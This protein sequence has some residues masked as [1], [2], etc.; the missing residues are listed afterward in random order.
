MPIAL[1]SVFVVQVDIDPGDVIARMGQ[2]ILND[3]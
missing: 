1:A 2:G 3:T